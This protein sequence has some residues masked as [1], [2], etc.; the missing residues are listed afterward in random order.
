MKQKKSILYVLGCLLCDQGSVQA[1]VRYAAT[2]SSTNDR[3]LFALRASI[4]YIDVDSSLNADV[5]STSFSS[6]DCHMMYRNKNEGV[7]GNT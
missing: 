2:L 3:L 7:K 1:S 4:R 6:P 5:L